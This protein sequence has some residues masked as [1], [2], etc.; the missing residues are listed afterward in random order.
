M[1]DQSPAESR[2]AENAALP[3]T[4]I[5][6]TLVTLLTQPWPDARWLAYVLGALA[7][8]FIAQRASRIDQ[9]SQT[10]T[11]S[12]LVIEGVLVIALCELGDFYFLTVMLSFI[13]V[14]LA[15]STLT[16]RPAMVHHGLLLLAILGAFALRV[17]I[18]VALPLVLGMP[19]GFIFIIAFTRLAR[20]EQQA[21]QQLEVANQQLTEYAAQVGQLATMRER[22]R[23]AR[24]V[25]DSLGHYLTV[26]NVQLEVVT[27]LLDSN[28]NKALKAAKRATELASEGLSEVRRSMAAL[29]PSPLDD[30]PLP[31]VL[32]SLIDTARE[33]GL[34]VTFEQSGLLR[35]ITPEVETVIYRATQEA[36]TNVRKHAHASSAHIR[37]TYAATTVQLSIRDNGVGRQHDEN[38]VGLTALRERVA[39][40]NGSV[41]AQN[42]P[43]GGFQIEVTL[44]A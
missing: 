43:E 6:F 38:N 23:L 30:R 3:G 21:R 24:E 14:S 11:L 17:S 32:K 4:I 37:L 33:A 10:Q 26:I 29:R 36:L 13:N 39:A 41:I 22:N 28:P 20:R 19:A 1:A 27:K 15:E 12:V 42:H 40:L 44:P 25:H 2:L 8:G 9:P 34:I 5:A 7:F 16:P 31:D 18:S 35:T